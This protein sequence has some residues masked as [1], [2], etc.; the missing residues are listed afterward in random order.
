MKNPIAETFFRLRQFWR[1]LLRCPACLK[2]FFH[3][4]YQSGYDLARGIQFIRAFYNYPRRLCNIGVYQYRI[5]LFQTLCVIFIVFFFLFTH[6][7]PGV[8]ILFHLFQTFFL[9]F[10][11]NQKEKFYNQ[12]AV[13]YEHFLKLCGIFFPNLSFVHPTIPAL[14]KDMH[15]SFFRSFCKKPPKIWAHFLFLSGFSGC[16]DPVAA[17]I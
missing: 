3:T 8:F 2:C 13:L 1:F 15:P 12:C 14:V 17:G 5:L 16:K 9:F 7:P 11:R 4:A 10:C 6:T